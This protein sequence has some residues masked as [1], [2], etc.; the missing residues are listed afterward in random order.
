[1]KKSQASDKNKCRAKQLLPLCEMKFWDRQYILECRQ[2]W[3][4]TS[5]EGNNYV[6]RHSPFLL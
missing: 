3:I 2:L 5:Q 1:M 4:F 6:L